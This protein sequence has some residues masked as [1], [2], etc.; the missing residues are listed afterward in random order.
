[1]PGRKR[2]LDRRKL[3][4][5]LLFPGGG[6]IATGDVFAAGLVLISTAFLW[7]TAV[8]ELVVNN[9]H[10]Y[11]APLHLAAEI[12][13]LKSPLTIVPHIIVAIILAL[14]VHIGAAWFAAKETSDATR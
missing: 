2:Q 9:M 8:L 3:T 13:K 4:C 5:G 12:A 6:Q 14:T 11:P 7:M 1:M 10:G